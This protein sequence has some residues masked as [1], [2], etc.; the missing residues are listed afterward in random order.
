MA[1][2]CTNI[3]KPM[4]YVLISIKD[5]S[6][7]KSVVSNEL[8]KLKV[9]VVSRHQMDIKKNETQIP[10]QENSNATQ[11]KGGSKLYLE[12]KEI[13]TIKNVRSKFLM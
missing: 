13:Y 9:R 3:S 8:S 7:W 12:L 2:N 6:L 4:I 5:S 10:C 1:Q 11:L